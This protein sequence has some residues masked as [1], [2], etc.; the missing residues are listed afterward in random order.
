MMSDQEFISELQKRARA[1]QGVEHPTYPMI[2]TSDGK[3]G[4]LNRKATLDL[5]CYRNF[6]AEQRRAMLEG[7]S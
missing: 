2:G 6:T 1:D 7:H 5:P 4:M 3:F